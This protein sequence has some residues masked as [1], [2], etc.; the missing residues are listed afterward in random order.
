MT[1]PPTAAARAI[2]AGGLQCRACLLGVEDS[3]GGR[4]WEERLADPRLGLALA[5][6]LDVPE[7]VGRILA[8]R[9]IGLDEAPAF[10]TPRLRDSMP[11]P[12]RLKDMDA[13][14]ARLVAAVMDGE[15]IAIFG[16]YD[17]DGATSAA[18]LV[19]FLRAAGVRPDPRVHVPDR[20]REGYGPNAPALRRL[21]AEGARVVVTVDC[22]IVAFEALAAAAEAGLDVIV[23]DHHAAEPRLPPA[24]AVVN[25]NRLDEVPSAMD[26]HRLG[27]LAAVGVAFLLVVALNRALRKAGWYDRAGRREPDLTRLLDLVA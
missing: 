3:L 2:P 1:A 9:G 25:P 15:R 4:R 7:I 6:R 18:L 23:V 12:S 14:V 8:A 16:D 21:R 20:L 17:V 22:G 10:L 13:A 19:R 26:P 11:D 27:A 5:Q 24:V